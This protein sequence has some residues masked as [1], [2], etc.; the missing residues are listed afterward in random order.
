MSEKQCSKCR[1]WKGLG[2]FNRDR[3]R[4]DGRRCECRTCKRVYDKRWYKANAEQCRN[5]VKRWRKANP[6]RY[7][8]NDRRWRKANAEQCG[9]YHRRTVAKYPL[10]NKARAALRH[11]VR[12]G[13]I[14][15]GP[16]QVCAS[17]IRIEAHHHKGYEPEFWLDVVWLCRVHHTEADMAM[18]S[19]AAPSP[20]PQRG[21]LP[22]EIA[23]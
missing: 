4:K 7:L 19:A 13:R 17:T 2:E 15:R 16:C 18:K 10:R 8:G 21:S 6:E 23:R 14:I 3:A 12:V 20:L 1:E 11:E 22:I 9:E 5:A